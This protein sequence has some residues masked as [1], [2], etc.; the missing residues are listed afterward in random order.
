[1][2]SVVVQAGGDSRRMG[3]DKALLPFLGKTLLRRVIERVDFLGDELLVTTNHPERFPDF[4]FPLVQDEMPGMGA[5]GGLYTALLAARFSTVIVVACDM[6][7][8]N[9]AILGD[10]CERLRLE[11]ADVVLPHTKDG[12]EPLHAVYRRETSLSAVRK[13]LEAGER[14]MISWF[15]AV[16]VIPLSE[17]VLVKYDPHQIAF[18]NLNT[19]EELQ[20]A[21]KLALELGE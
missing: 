11:E 6:P 8:V 21:E 4:D 9:A 5:L 3:Q 14:R 19:P 12:Y 15:P 16:K 17:H 13:A 10:A 18:W 2:I 1:M 7:F 20:Q